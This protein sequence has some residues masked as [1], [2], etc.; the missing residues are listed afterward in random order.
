MESVRS[1]RLDVDG[2]GRDEDKNDTQLSTFIAAEFS[3]AL[4]SYHPGTTGR[5]R[6]TS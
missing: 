5:W 4:A 3:D 6:H 1:E 2:S